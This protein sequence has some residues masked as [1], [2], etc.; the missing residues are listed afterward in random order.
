MKDFKDIKRILKKIKKILNKRYKKL[1]IVILAHPRSSIAVSLLTLIIIVQGFETNS[2]NINSRVIIKHDK[3]ISFK[4]GH[5]IGSGKNLYKRKEKMLYSQFKELKEEL[6]RDRE[7]QRQ[8]ILVMSHLEKQIKKQ[9][10]NPSAIKEGNEPP[11]S[12]KEATQA[13]SSPSIDS[14]VQFSTPSEKIQSQRYQNT[15]SPVTS[16]TKIKRNPVTRKF[17]RRSSTRGPAIISFPVE[18]K[19][20]LKKQK[21]NIPTGSFVMATMLTG[22]EAP[23]GKALPVLLKADFAFIGPNKSKIDLSG[24]FF[25]GK[26]TG[27]LSIERVELQ[28]VKMSCVSKSGRSFESSVNGFVADEEDN[29]FAVVGKVNGKRDRVAAM[30]FLSSIVEGVGKAI[31]QGQTTSS[32]GGLGGSSLSVTGSQAKHMYAGGAANAASRITD[33]YLKHAEGLLP[34]INV[35]SGRQ[36][37]IIMQD[38]IIMPNWFFKKIKK[39]GTREFSYLSRVLD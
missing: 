22:V 6:K 37:Y 17:K 15:R 26:S 31:Q 30:A 5:V 29:S 25:I 39:K 38:K 19:S 33:F 24:C 35:G 28:V 4:G 13:S 8:L 21:V 20:G 23:E 7:K 27:N 36:V 14:N 1:K 34:T 32:S 9:K 12:D 18:V 3:L 16:P 2:N 10:N 11:S